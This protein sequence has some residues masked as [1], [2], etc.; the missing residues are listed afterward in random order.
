MFEHQRCIGQ[1]RPSRVRDDFDI[2][3]H[4]RRDQPAQA[5]REIERVFRGY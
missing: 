4:I 3:Q 2:R 1:Q 5:P